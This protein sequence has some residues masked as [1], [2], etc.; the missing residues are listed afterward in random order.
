VNKQVAIVV[1]GEVMSSPTIQPNLLS[2]F[3]ATFQVNANLSQ[4][5]A[6]RVAEVFRSGL[7]G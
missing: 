1:D 2:N 7:A 6:A 3:N 4:A 5:D